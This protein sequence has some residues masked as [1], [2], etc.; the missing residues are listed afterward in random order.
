MA[1]S[2]SYICQQE[3][4]GGA[5]AKAEIW[6]DGAGIEDLVG[7]KKREERAPIRIR[8]RGQE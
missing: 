5:R 3:S 8:T 1:D 6:R 7:G 4:Q 2:W